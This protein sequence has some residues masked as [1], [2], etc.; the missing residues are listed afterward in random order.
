MELTVNR[1]LEQGVVAHKEGRLEEAEKLYRA[2]LHIQPNHPDA[3]HNLGLIAFT[4]DKIEPA[5]LLFKTAVEAN[6]RIEQFWISYIST[7]IKDKQFENAKH[8]IEQGRKQ[9]VAGEKVNALAT[10]L[11]FA[12]QIEMVSLVGPSQQQLSNLTEYYQTGRYD[13]AKKLAIYITQNFPS[14]QFGWKVLGAL[15]MQSGENSE[16]INPNQTAVRLSPEDSAAHNNLGVTLKALGRLDEAK[17]R[18]KKAIALKPGYAEAHNNLG[19]TLKELGRL[20]EAE[21][22]CRQAIALKPG[23]AEAYNNLGVTLQKQ[24]RLDEAEASYREAIEWT[25]N[26]VEA[27]NNLGN[28]LKEL[29]RLDEA[30]LSCKRAIALKPGYAEAHNNLG[31]ILQEQGRL[32]EAEASYREAIVFIPDFAKAHRHLAAIKKF[33]SKDK[34]YSKM[35]ELYLDN[36]ISEE[37]RCN[38]NFGLAKACED[39]GNFEQAFKHYDE[40]NKLRRKLLNYN[41]NQDIELFRQLRSNY[42]NIQKH[43][44]KLHKLMD[45]PTPIFIVGMPRSGTTLVEQIISSHPKVTGAGELPFATQ[46]GALIARGSSPV[47]T[48]SLHEFRTQYLTKLQNVSNEN[49]IV[50]DKMPQNF[51]Y[52]GLLA[53]SFPEARII[54]VRRSPSAVCWA[55]YTQYFVSKNLGYSYALDDVVN[56]YELYRDL[57]EFWSVSLSKRIYN[58]D[59]ELLTINQEN[60][61]RK[62]IRYLAI[63]WDK[64]CLS[65]QNNTRSVATASNMQIRKKIYQ[66]SSEKWKRYKPFLANKLDFSDNSH[67]L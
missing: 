19:N 60:E 12:N 8:V 5:L 31:I 36:S 1:A 35:L 61:T 54:H 2:V 62:L 21:V 42:P 45:N 15:L 50:T 46:L 18:Y 41:I 63:N 57:M 64:R 10:Q 28:T 27:Y 58:L 20:D 17:I 44:L 22:S 52:V 49:K 59:Y 26:F 39:L 53:A 37:Q 48:N 55:N 13:N 51:L 32:N 34:Q 23:Y 14:H 30:E 25:P 24:G 56:Y 47:D 65:P 3:N 7:L 40:G 43:S 11:T 6:P 29:D 38:I 33:N 67:E 66:G 4:T 16:A 9:G